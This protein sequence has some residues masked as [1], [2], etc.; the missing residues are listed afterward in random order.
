M[1]K[2]IIIIILIGLSVVFSYFLAL[3]QYN[4][5]AELRSHVLD[6][7]E[8]LRNR[9]EYISRLRGL[10][11]GLRDHQPAVDKINYAF[12]EKAD[13]PEVLVFLEQTASTNGLIIEEINVSA[14]SKS[15]S[16]STVSSKIREKELTVS[17]LGKV[18]SLTSFLAEVERS[19]R[20]LEIDSLSFEYLEGELDAAQEIFSFEVIFNV[21]S[22]S[23]ELAKEKEEPSLPVLEPREISID[24]DFLSSLGLEELKTPEQILLPEG[25][26]REN[27]FV[28][29]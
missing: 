1:S 17:L 12:P 24:F 27:P 7:Q 5:L 21:H 28:P 26:G 16:A 23:N 10:S 2:L 19:A 13:V 29:Y 11:D 25:I 6:T 8:E 20:L 18:E 22:W 9:E 14:K 3:P 15:A 4:N